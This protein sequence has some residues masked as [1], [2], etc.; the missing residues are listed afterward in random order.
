VTF[1]GDKLLG[2][3][4]AGIIL[5]R[6][7][8]IAQCKKNPL[9]RALRVDKMILAAL[10]ATLRLYRDEPTAWRRV[11]TL[12]MIARPVKALEDAAHRLAARIRQCPCSSTLDVEVMESVSQVGGGALPERNLP[13]FV[14]SVSSK[15]WSAARLEQFFRASTPPIIGR[16]ESD[17]FLMDMRTLQEGDADIIVR[18]FAQLP[19]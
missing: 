4:Q 7:D 16:I 1:S 14:V 8:L 3:P 9:T 18:A 19:A 17:R 13:T 15:R 5:G 10:E 12:E 11:P 6:K 2:G